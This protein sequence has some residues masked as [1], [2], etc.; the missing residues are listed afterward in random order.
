MNIPYVKRYNENG[1]LLNPIKAGQ[2][3]VSP[4]SN[5]RARRETRDRKW[6]GKKPGYRFMGCGKNF[7]LTING[8]LKY[9]RR[10]QEVSCKDG[11]IRRVEHNDL[12]GVNY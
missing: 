4:Y 7:S 11:S 6:G 10:I 12:K 9:A 1:E 2:L 8:H 5:R 3:Y